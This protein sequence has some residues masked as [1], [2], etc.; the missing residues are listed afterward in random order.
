MRFKLKIVFYWLKLVFAPKLKRVGSI[1]KFQKQKLEAFANRTLI[2]SPYY[3][4]FF[5]SNKFQWENVPQITKKE[6]MES[7]DAINTQGIQITE[8]M[9]VAIS[10]EQTR[11]FKS[12]IDGITVGL[13][14]GTSGKRGLFLV[15][16]D[17][18]AQWVALVMSRVIKPKLFKKQKIAFFLRANSNLYASISSKLFEFKYFDI[19]KPI[20]ELL[21]EL[22]EYQPHILASQP[23]LMMD[24][25]KAQK[26]REIDIHPIQII[27]FAEVLHQGDR[28]I[29]ESVFNTKITEVYQCT[30]GFLGASCKFGTMHLNEDF[31]QFEKEWIDENKFY[32]II[33]DFTRQTQPVV[34]YKLND[35][36]QIKEREC[37]CGSKL[38]AIEKII[39]RDDDVLIMN[40]IK[41]YPDLLARKIALK[42]DSFQKY[43]I[44]QVSA[45]KLSIEIDCTEDDRIEA[46]H[47]F[48]STIGDF[49]GELG[50]ENVEYE[51]QKQQNQIVGNKTRKIKRL[52]YEN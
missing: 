12:E 10:A 24:I 33:T 34:K 22:N 2:K 14:T 49:L 45:N 41:V 5:A 4:K 3:A 29:I 38:L 48:K 44:T 15:S 39:G 42:T 20:S 52:H 17:E 11:D 1:Q 26:N 9:D 50:I 37:K 40:N 13:S 28:G 31:I 23:S 19:F 7:F 51:F 6:F 36:L 25:A 21:E 43:L 16:L 30:E 35:V 8:A 18:R 32:P 27:S 46:E 47:V